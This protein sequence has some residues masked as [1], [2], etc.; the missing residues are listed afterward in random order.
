MSFELTKEYVTD[1]KGLISGGEDKELVALMGELYPADIAEI[2]GELKHE[3]ASYLFKHLDEE[4]GADVL[5]ELEEDE[6]EKLLAQLTSREIASYLDQNID[7]DD[8]AD[9]VAELPDRKQEEVISQMQ[10]EEQASDIIDLLNYEEGTAGA[11]MAKELIMVKHTWTVATTIR[12]MR[13]QAEDLDNVYTIYVVDDKETLMGRLSL[14]RLLF[15]SSSTRTQ[16]KDIF[17]DSALH[18]VTVDTPVE[19][20][21]SIMEKYDLV[22]LPVVNDV[23][24]LLGRITIDDVVDI[25]KREAEKDYQLA[26]G[27][28]EDVE[29][30]D[31]TWLLVRARLPWLLIGLVGGIMGAFVIHRYEGFIGIYPE[32]A[33]FIPLIAAMGGNVG[34]QSSAIIVQALANNNVP[35]STTWQKMVKET[36]V[37]LVNGGVLALL[38]LAYNLAF[39]DSLALS[40]TVSISLLAVVLFAALFGMFTPLALDRFNID[41]ALATG[42]FITTANDII[43]LFIYFI[44]GRMMY[45]HFEGDPVGQWQDILPLIT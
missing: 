45:L 23:G 28:S 12:E 17:E 33:F 30:D 13:K 11:I 38:I 15:S 44:V 10:D 9:L 1:L 26:S 31:G 20:V 35:L 7:S 41:P 34:I 14:K 3:E 39:D 4:V 21:A 6:R 22:A 27:I 29:A 36:G 16:V 19:E 43:G 42:P 32:M 18:T 24:Q 37:A 25:I 8:A 2:I 5:V 40:Y